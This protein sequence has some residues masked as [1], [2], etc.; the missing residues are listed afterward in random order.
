M[1]KKS[2]VFARRVRIPHDKLQTILF[3]VAIYLPPQTDAG[4]K[5]ALTELYRATSIEENAHLEQPL[6]VARDFNAEKLKSI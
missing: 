2:H 5:T 3:F 1:L 6:L 4:T